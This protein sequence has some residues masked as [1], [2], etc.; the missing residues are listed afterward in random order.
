MSLNLRRAAG[1]AV[2]ALVLGALAPAAPGAAGTA[3]GSH[4]DRHRAPVAATQTG[5]VRGAAERGVDSFLG[6]PFA[7]PPVGD[8][9][10]A[11]P[12]PPARWRGVRDATEFGNR[13]PATESTNGPR[14]ET[15]DCLFVN[16]QRPSDLRRG[17]RRPVFVFIH[18]GGLNNGSSNQMDM[19]K[20][21]SA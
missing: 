5:L 19:S 20:V 12:R 3:P 21:S 16:V 8:L 4:G 17:E 7:A 9:R 1:G 13:C 11:A 10:W 2:L 15:E 18:G 14:S 6:I